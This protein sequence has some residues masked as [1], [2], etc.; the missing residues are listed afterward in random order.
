M[1]TVDLVTREAYQRCWD[2]DCVVRVAC[3]YVKARHFLGRVPA[4]VCV[5]SVEELCAALWAGGLVCDGA[6]PPAG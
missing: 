4:C 2:P 3:G 6:A 1:V 5:P